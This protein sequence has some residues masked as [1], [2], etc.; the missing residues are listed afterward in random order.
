MFLR[1]AR[2]RMEARDP[3]DVPLLALALALKVPIWTHDRDFEVA[4][5]EKYTTA[6]LLTKLGIRGR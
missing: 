3:D 5:V 6:R 2:R 4:G 1:E